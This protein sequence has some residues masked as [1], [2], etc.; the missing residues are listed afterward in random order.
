M[1][2][3]GADAIVVLGGDGAHR[4]EA[5]ECEPV[6]VGGVSTG[7]INSFSDHREPTTTDLATGLVA[8]S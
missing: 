8:T 5:N 7:T 6:P 3:A 1:R 4:A 2:D